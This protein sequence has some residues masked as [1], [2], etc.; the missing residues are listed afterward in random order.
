MRTGAKLASGICTA[1]GA[2]NNSVIKT[3]IPW[4]TP[5]NG[6][7]APDLIFVAVRAMA[8]VAG[9]PPKNGVTIL[10]TPARS[11]PGYCYVCCSSSHL[12]QPLITVIQSHRALQ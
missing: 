7:T 9:I 3:K 4:I 5:D 10:A 11:I 1:N 6:D 8:P 2:S 12:Q